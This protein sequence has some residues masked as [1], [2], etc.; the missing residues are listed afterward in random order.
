MCA[1]G[2]SIADGSR[3]WQTANWRSWRSIDR[4]ARSPAPTWRSWCPRRS[5]APRGRSWTPSIPAHGRRGAAGRPTARGRRAPAR[6]GG[7]DPSTAPGPGP[8]P[9]APRRGRP[10]HGY[11]QA[12]ATPAVPGTEAVRAGRGMDHRLAGAG[13]RRSCGARP[14]EQGDQPDGI[15]GAH[16][17]CARRVGPTAVDRRTRRAVPPRSASVRPSAVVRHSTFTCPGV[18]SGRPAAGGRPGSQSNR[19]PGACATRS[20]TSRSDSMAKTQ[21]PSGMSRRSMRSGSR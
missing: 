16:G 20:R 5:P 13:D 4:A 14:A 6:A 18:I 15:H 9:G 19:V 2:M 8:G 17:R 10:T 3:R 1:K 21:R 12:D 11:R 7:P